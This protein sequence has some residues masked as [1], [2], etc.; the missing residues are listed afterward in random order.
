MNKINRIIKPY[1]A[2][3]N[4]NHTIRRLNSNEKSCV[5]EIE[6]TIIFDKKFRICKHC[7]HIDYNGEK[8]KKFGEYIITNGKYDV[9]MGKYKHL[10]A[11]FCRH[12][13]N[14]CGESAVFYE[15]M[16]HKESESKAFTWLVWNVAMPAVIV[17]S[18]VVAFN[19]IIRDLL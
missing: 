11:D 7:K 9:V 3:S 2:V 1:Q 5:P 13:E 16:T 6:N 4:F 8:C 12:D 18:G 19:M 15:E 14:K 10:P 17:V